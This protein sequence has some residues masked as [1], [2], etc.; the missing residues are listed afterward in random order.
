MLRYYL[1]QLLQPVRRFLVQLS[2][3]VLPQNALVDDV[4][5]PVYPQLPVFLQLTQIFFKHI[6]I[7]YLNFCRQNF[8]LTIY[9]GSNTFDTSAS[10][11][12]SLSLPSLSALSRFVSLSSNLSSSRPPKQMTYTFYAWNL[13][14]VFNNYRMLIESAMLIPDDVSPLG[15]SLM[16]NPNSS[17]EMVV[18][19][20]RCPRNGSILSIKLYWF[21]KIHTLTRQFR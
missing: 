1:S 13:L 9:E 21:Y 18:I 2:Y 11:S 12:L 4:L 3:L 6:F 5:L 14:T 7:A 8:I 17:I 10:S 20:G 19:N 16:S 15:L